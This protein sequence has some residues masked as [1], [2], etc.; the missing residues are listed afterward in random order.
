AV[1]IEAWL[2]P[3]ASPGSGKGCIVADWGSGA[4]PASNWALSYVTGGNCT[5][6]VVKSPNSW[7]DQG[8]INFTTTSG[9]ITNNAWHHVAL[10]YD[11]TANLRCFING[12]LRGSSAAFT[13]G[14]S[15]NGHSANLTIGNYTS[16]ATNNFVGHMDDVRITKGV[17]RYTAG[18]S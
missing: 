6:E 7:F 4:G 11:G 2:Y 9:G 13:Q 15:S 10:T 17:C 1:T 16:F 18:F 8:N 12:V 3:T 5:V 14:F